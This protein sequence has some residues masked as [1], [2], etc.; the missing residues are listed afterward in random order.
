MLFRSLVAK[1]DKE[2]SAAKSKKS[3]TNT[4]SKKQPLIIKSRKT[5]KLTP[6]QQKD[7]AGGKYSYMEL[8]VRN[9][10]V[11]VT[12]EQFRKLYNRKNLRTYFKM[13]TKGRKV[14]KAKKSIKKKIFKGKVYMLNM[15]ISGKQMKGLNAGISSVGKVKKK[16]KFRMMKFAVKKAKK[17]KKKRG[18][19]AKK[20]FKLLKRGGLFKAIFDKT[21]KKVYFNTKGNPTKTYF[22]LVKIQPK[23]SKK[24]KKGKRGKVGGTR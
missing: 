8:I 16:T 15:V 10:S 24:A 17:V 18:K 12:P 11:K 5:I 3:N 13:V 19:K 23:K 14:V 20:A 21:V 2:P 6:A 22:A 4:S 1:L 9:V 7:M